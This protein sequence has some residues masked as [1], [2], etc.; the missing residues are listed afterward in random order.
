M[1]LSALIAKQFRDLH[2][3][4][5][6]TGVNLKET[7]KDLSWQEATEKIDSFNTIATLMYHTHYYVEI[8]TN[9]LLG[10][11]LQGKDTDSFEHPP[12]Q[13]RE[14]W[15]Q[16]LEHVWMDAENFALLVEGLPDSKLEEN[17]SGEKYGSYFRNI[18]GIT[19]HTHYHLGQIVLLKKMI[20]E[21]VPGNVPV[22]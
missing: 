8:V 1:T 2:F 11:P 15:E 21:K 7:V 12:V 3:G 10:Q 4:G 13:S 20:R 16:L 5:N 6:W 18:Q 22:K 14:N 17:F 19:E 9:V